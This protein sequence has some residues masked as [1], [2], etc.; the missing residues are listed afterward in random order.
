LQLLSL[1]RSTL[2]L[3]VDLASSS[4]LVTATLLSGSFL[5]MF[6]HVIYWCSLHMWHWSP[7]N[8]SRSFYTKTWKA[9]SWT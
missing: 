7:F 9:L 2:M 4:C 5:T 3:K 8:V 6:T 1:E